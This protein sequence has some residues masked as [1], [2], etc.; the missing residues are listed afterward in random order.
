MASSRMYTNENSHE[1]NKNARLKVG[2]E[3]KKK[4]VWTELLRSQHDL[5][6]L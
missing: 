2:D 6:N 1:L 4:L 5:R 3:E